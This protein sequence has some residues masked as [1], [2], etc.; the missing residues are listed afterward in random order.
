MRTLLLLAFS[1]ISLSYLKAQEAT[2][3]YQFDYMEDKLN[4]ADLDQSYSY[5]HF[6]GERIG[7]KLALLSDSY[8]W[9][10][11][12]TATTPVAMTIV[13]KPLI[14]NN[15]KKLERFYKKGI[16]KDE[17]TLEEAAVAFEKILD[18]ALLVRY[19]ETSAL[20]EDLKQIKEE[21]ELVAIF[22]E[23]VQ[24]REY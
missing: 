18:I 23:K 21:T 6:M 4:T 22:S 11:E 5:N 8:T 7:K 20:E 16:R 13:E 9:K 17:I 3:S 1:I 24:V 15:V 2:A 19:Q 12:A 10:E 14:Y